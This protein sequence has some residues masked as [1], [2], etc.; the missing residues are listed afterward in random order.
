MLFIL[1][2]VYFGNMFYLV[3]VFLGFF[4]N[5]V[6]SLLF[7]KKAVKWQKAEKRKV[8]TLHSRD[9]LQRNVQLK[10]TFPWDKKR[11]DLRHIVVV[12]QEHCVI[13]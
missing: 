4:Q 11:Q 13:S 9:G 3:P 10:Q 6:F 2:E 1:I 12:S 5:E 7:L 8:L